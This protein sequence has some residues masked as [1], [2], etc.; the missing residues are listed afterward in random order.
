[1]NKTIAKKWIKALRSGA[2]EQG[3]DMLVT[4]TDQFCCLGVLCNLAV[5]AGVGKWVKGDV[6]SQGNEYGFV[7]TKSDASS[8]ELPEAVRTWAGMK[9]EDGRLPFI[10][11]LAYLNDGGATFEEIADIIEA[12]I[13]AL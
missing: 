9:S 10:H 3:Q 1:M 7:V 4:P 12:N 6:D 2:Y 13:E 11:S 5:D 8:Y